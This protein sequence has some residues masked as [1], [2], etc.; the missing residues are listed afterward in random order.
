MPAK[1]TIPK[2]LLAEDAKAALQEALKALDALEKPPALKPLKTTSEG[3][4]LLGGTAEM[5]RICG[6]TMQQVS[7][8]RASG[9]FSPTT[10]YLL[11][12]EFEKIGYEA[13]PR[14]WRMKEPAK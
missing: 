3:I 5:S 11:R 7:D 9:Y 13:T 8:W 6:A 10:Y 14:L 4:D 2:E 12:P 1:K